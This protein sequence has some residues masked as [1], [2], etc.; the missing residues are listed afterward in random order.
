M[1]TTMFYSYSRVQV[2]KPSYTYA[3]N[4]GWGE[5]IHGITAYVYDGFS[6]QTLS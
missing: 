2:E 4:E 6:H 5:T 1:A 3:G